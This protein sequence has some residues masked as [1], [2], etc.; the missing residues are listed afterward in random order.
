MTISPASALFEVVHV[1]DS[2]PRETLG[3]LGRYAAWRHSLEHHAAGRPGR[4]ASTFSGR[5][6]IGQCAPAASAAP[7]PAFSSSRARSWS[8]GS[9]C[10]RYSAATRRRAAGPARFGALAADA[11]YPPRRR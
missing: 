10:W 8:T 11:I 1:T 7:L 9:P 6:R 5:P 4:P 3:R 2:L